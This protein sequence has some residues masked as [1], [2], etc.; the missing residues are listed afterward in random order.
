MSWTWFLDALVIARDAAIVVGVLLIVLGL[1]GRVDLSHPRC[2]CCKADLRLLSWELAS[3]AAHDDRRPVACLGCGRL[4]TGRAVR[5]RPFP[6][7][8]RAVA[9]GALLV[10]VAIGSYAWTMARA[11]NGLSWRDALPVVW[12]L[13]SAE[14]TGYPGSTGPLTPANRGFATWAAG[15]WQSL[16]RR[17]AAGLL[18]VEQLTAAA[19]TIERSVAGVDA[20]TIGGPQPFVRAANW[21]APHADLLIEIL[22]SDIDP[23]LRSAAASLIDSPL[24]L[25]VSSATGA[26]NP[27][28]SVRSGD[29]LLL[30]LQ[31]GGKA[32]LRGEHSWF[33]M[34]YERSTTLARE[35]SL[36]ALFHVHEVRLNDQVI[37]F[38]SERPMHRSGSVIEHG[39]PNRS[40]DP[41][42]MPVV[43]CVIEAP[44][45]VHELTMVVDTALVDVSLARAR[46]SRRTAS[47]DR[48]SGGARARSCSARSCDTR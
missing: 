17:A 43:S 22:R 42:W 33:E 3:G 11:R 25:A 46:S 18:S 44:A 26:G 14:R 47:P 38:S 9:A 35:H 27:D 21:P 4:L 23:A 16:N 31:S 24:I 1:L 30:R 19:R 41:D 5:W 37:P 39:H 36:D 15:P 8:W 7:A 48:R 20:A 34:L 32:E 13:R 2:R 6:I 28:G 29:R 10:A 45:G 12:D 40:D